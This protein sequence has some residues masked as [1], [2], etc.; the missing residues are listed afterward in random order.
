MLR[1]TRKLRAGCLVPPAMRETLAADGC[2]ESSALCAAD[3]PRGPVRRAR[4]LPR[5]RRSRR[6]LLAELPSSARP[7]RG[8]AEAP[9]LSGRMSCAPHVMTREPARTRGPSAERR[10]RPLLRTRRTPTVDR[11]RFA[12]PGAGR[13]AARLRRRSPRDVRIRLA[14]SRR[15]L[16]PRA[17]H[18]RR[19]SHGLALG[20]R[21]TGTRVLGVH[22]R[23]GE[24]AHT[25]RAALV[26][27]VP[28]FPERCGPGGGATD[29]DAGR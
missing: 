28:A 6:A 16:A 13:H 8:R 18:S 1:R 10:R 9:E 22:Y 17:L 12:S 15:E 4:E 24:S 20:A 29:E 5:T 2:G 23:A 19:P 14:T 7:A 26:I 11:A 21:A 27:E 25:L 3:V